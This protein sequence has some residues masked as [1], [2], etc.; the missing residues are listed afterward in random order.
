[1]NSTMQAVQVDQVNAPLRVIDIPQPGPGRGQVRITVEACGVCRTDADMVQGVFGDQVFP[2][3]PGHEIAGRIDMLGE[4]VEGWDLGERVAVGWF[5]GNDGTC[6]ACREG[7]AINCEHLQVPGLAYPGGYAESVVVPTSALARIPDELS[8]VEAAPMGCAGVTVFNGLRRTSAESGDLVAV[9]GIGGLGHLALQFADKMGFDTVAIARGSDKEESARQLGAR[10][11]IDDAG[12]DMAQAL[13]ALG[14][15][16]VVMATV[17]APAAMSAAIDGLRA[18]GEL[19]TIGVSTNKIEISPLQLITG[20]KTLHGHASGTSQEVEETMR[21]AAQSGV[22]C[23]SQ[24][25]PL[26]DAP[27]AYD[28]MLAGT[29][30]Y[31]GVLTPAGGTGSSPPRA[32]AATGARGQT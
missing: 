32:H 28:N 13:Q 15:A 17:G 18:R 26:Q 24:V 16:K 6:E 14:G 19:V 9:L 25:A 31:R 8:F 1:M 5:G 23:I 7:D 2:L 21:F 11:Y 12:Q 22:R 27:Q 20:E 30:R 10:H 4:G 3:T 29:V